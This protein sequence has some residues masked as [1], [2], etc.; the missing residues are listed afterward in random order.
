MY[1]EIA[2]REI[3]ANSLIHQDFNELGFPM[4]KIFSDRIEISNPGLPLIEP[5][6]FFDE[7]VSRNEK[8]ADIMRRMGFAKKKGAE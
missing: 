7:Y 6:R 3:F 2:I 1:P 4:V 8:M 5:E